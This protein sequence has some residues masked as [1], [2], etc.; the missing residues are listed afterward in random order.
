MAEFNFSQGL[1]RMGRD[2]S[3][4]KQFLPSIRCQASFRLSGSV[5]ADDVAG[6]EP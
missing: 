5:K 2:Y 3:R 6:P 4:R 1:A